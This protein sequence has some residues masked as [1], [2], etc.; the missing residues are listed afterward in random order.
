MKKVI[1][2]YLCVVNNFKKNI[3]EVV[4]PPLF[5]IQDKIETAINAINAKLN[6]LYFFKKMTL[7]FFIKYSIE[8]IANII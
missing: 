5:I 7:I 8:S 2:N 4:N 3:I 1:V 6:F